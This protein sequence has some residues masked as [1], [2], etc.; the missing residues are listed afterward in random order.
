M[1]DFIKKLFVMYLLFVIRTSMVMYKAIYLFLDKFIPDGIIK[2]DHSEED[3]VYDRDEIFSDDK[4]LENF[5]GDD[6][7]YDKEI[8]DFKEMLTLG[9]MLVIAIVGIVLLIK[10]DIRLANYGRQTN[11]LKSDIFDGKLTGS[12]GK[13]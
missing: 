13:L 1:L 7:F 5:F 2:K 8:D 10:A 6:E 3:N 11:Y 9:I 4:F 12:I